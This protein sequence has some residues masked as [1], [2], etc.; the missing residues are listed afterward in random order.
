MSAEGGQIGPLTR[1]ME[2]PS[3]AACA[4]TALPTTRSTPK[5]VE[6]QLINPVCMGLDDA[7]PFPPN[8][9][10]RRSR[11]CKALLHLRVGLADRLPALVTPGFRYRQNFKA[12][13]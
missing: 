12:E 2:Q 7:L 1:H 4:G 8:E 6:E 3:P 11:R 13:G 10:A 5:S 9:D